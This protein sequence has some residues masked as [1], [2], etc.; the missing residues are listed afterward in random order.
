MDT[1]VIP[2][3]TK[4]GQVV[5]AYTPPEQ[6]DLQGFLQLLNDFEKRFFR[7]VDRGYLFTDT[8]VVELD[9][10]LHNIDNFIDNKTRVFD[11][12]KGPEREWAGRMLACAHLKRGLEFAKKHIGLRIAQ[13]KRPMNEAEL[14]KRL[15]D[16]QTSAFADFAEGMDDK[17]PRL[18]RTHGVPDMDQVVSEM[19]GEPYN[20]FG[21][22]MDE[23]G[24]LK[25]FYD[26]RYGK[27]A[28][29]MSCID[30]VPEIMNPL[31]DKTTA[32]LQAAPHSKTRGG[33][34]IAVKSDN[35]DVEAIRQIQGK[36]LEFASIA[37]KRIQLLR[38]DKEF[39]ATDLTL[40]DIR[41]SLYETA[42]D[43][44]NKATIFKPGSP[45]LAGANA[46]QDVLLPQM[47]DTL[48]L[49]V[50]CIYDMSTTHAAQPKLVEHLSKNAAL[51]LAVLDASLPPDSPKRGR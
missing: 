31:I 32:L 44:Y 19:R 18:L 13:A 16:L 7:N 2:P 22:S 28:S 36:M 14:S 42:N 46:T 51:T 20:I 23:P 40:A 33:F 29:A 3:V 37:K 15:E 43:L 17:Y 8:G 26:N 10:T 45:R 30:Q 6:H 9:G 48:K 34:R 47:A 5:K 50:H 39:P 21:A 25:T 24:L 35:P 38:S 41:T 4:D 11:T 1:R 27:I 49:A 12:A